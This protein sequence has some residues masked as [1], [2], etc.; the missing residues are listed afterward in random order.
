MVGIWL[1][2]VRGANKQAILSV[3]KS[4][5]AA[6]QEPCVLI[7]HEEDGSEQQLLP[8]LPSSQ[9]IV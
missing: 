3:L 4:W 7:K 9:S 6:W 5:F 1:E 8:I 2:Q